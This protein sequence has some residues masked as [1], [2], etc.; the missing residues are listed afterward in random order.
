MVGKS[1]PGTTLRQWVLR[2]WVPHALFTLGCVLSLAATW[3]VSST[4]E[5]RIEAA[6][7]N[8]RA[9]FLTEAENT[10]QQIQV[11]LN[12]DVELIRAGAALL[13]ASNEISQVEFRTFVAGLQLRR[14]YSGMAA[15]GFAPRVRPPD[16]GRFA[17]PLV[18]MGSQAF[19]RGALH[20]KRSTTRFSFWS[21]A[22]ESAARSSV[23]T[24]P[25]IRF[26]K[27]RWTARVIQESP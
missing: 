17:E 25:P 26:F 19:G 24:F 23:M 8:D 7:L 11:R 4:T 18:L 3:Y 13:A 6:Y 21:R 5:A 20:P 15:M 1:H 22:T 2:R 14:R 12:T 16:C 27:N 9:R 10:R